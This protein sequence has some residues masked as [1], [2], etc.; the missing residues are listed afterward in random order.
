MSDS[1]KEHKIESTKLVEWTADV[2]KRRDVLEA[3]LRKQDKVT[4]CALLLQ[5]AI[6]VELACK[7]SKFS[8]KHV[9][10][11]SLRWAKSDTVLMVLRAQSNVSDALGTV[12]SSM[13][14]VDARIYTKVQAKLKHS[15]KIMTLELDLKS[16]K[17]IANVRF[18]VDG[19]C[20]EIHCNVA[21][22]VALASG[23]RYTIKKKTVSDAEV[24]P[25][26]SNRRV[27]K[28]LAEE[29]GKVLD[30]VGQ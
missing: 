12:N 28:D 9:G 5:N 29:R 19:D 22:G 11:A 16:A 26:C 17:A 4:T 10:C 1:V 23:R 7:K 21:R 6:K 13:K 20:K 25:R 15:W 27:T 3:E 18:S 24:A 2:G 30:S 14:S 8:T